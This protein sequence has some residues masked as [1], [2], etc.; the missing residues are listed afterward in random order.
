MAKFTGVESEDSDT[1]AGNRTHK[2][3][4]ERWS[5]TKDLDFFAPTFRVGIVARIWAELPANDEE[6]AREKLSQHLK[7]LKDG[8]CDI[9]LN[10]DVDEFY[11]EKISD[12]KLPK[13][14]IE[15]E[16]EERKTLFYD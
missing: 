15:K 11:P 8:D 2:K 14:R 1:E 12:G 5:H 16:L 9:R 3:Y 4:P 6:D 10:F 7:W 13:E